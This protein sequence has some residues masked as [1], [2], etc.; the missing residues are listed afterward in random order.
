MNPPQKVWIRHATAWHCGHPPS[1]SYEE[2]PDWIPHVPESSIAE[3][4][5]E[6]RAKAF[7]QGYACAISCIVKGHGEDTGTR[8]ALEANGIE[9]FAKAKAAGVDEY[10]L[11]VLFKARSAGG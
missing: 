7:N 8:E 3:A 9:T 6:A 11:N 4:V 1:V 5:K 10:D 2:Y